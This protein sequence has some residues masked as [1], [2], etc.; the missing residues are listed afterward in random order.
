MPVPAF[1][2]GLPKSRT[3]T[4]LDA[5]RLRLEERRS[6]FDRATDLGEVTIKIK[7]QAGST[8]VRAVEVSEERVFRRT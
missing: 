4:I 6:L 3:E 7:L 8:L 5:V 2:A 1:A